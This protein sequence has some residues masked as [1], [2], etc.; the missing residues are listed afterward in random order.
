MEL[1]RIFDIPEYQKKKYPKS[2]ALNA[3][4][5]GQWRAYG[6]DECIDNINK[7]SLALLASGI[8]KD[9]KISIISNNRPEWNFVDFGIMQIGAVNVPVYPTSAEEDYVFIFNDAEVKMVFVSS[10]ELF[11]KIQNIKSRIPSL[12]EVFTFNQVKGASHFSEFMER[13]K[14]GSV[15]E[16]EK[17]KSGITSDDIST[18]IY[19][20]G[21]TGFPKGVM[22]SHWNVL[23]DVIAAKPLMPVGEKDKALS[24]LPLNHSFEKMISYLYLCY[25]I[26]IYY[27]ES[28]DTIGDN[29]REV[30]PQIMT[31]VP[32][33]LEKVYEKIL[34]KGQEQKGIKRALFFWALSLGER[35]DN[36]KSNG[37]FYPIQMAIANKLVFSKWRAALGGQ[38]KCVVTGAAPM[39]HKLLRI[40]TAAKITI[41]EGYGLTET[42]PAISVSRFN[43]DENVIGCVGPAIPGVEIKIAEDGEIL[44]R[45][46][47]VMKGYYKRPDLT[48]EVIDKDGWLHTGD[49]G[50]LVNGK[51]LKITDRKKELFKTSGGKYVAPQPIENKFKEELL[52]EQMIVVGASRKF[53]AALIVPSANNLK[54]WCTQHGINFTNTSEMIR[55]EAVKKKFEQLV[56][57]NNKLFGH[58][59]QIKK[60]TL[61]PNEWTIADGELTPTLKLKRKIIEKKFE[62]EIEAMYEEN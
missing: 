44:C 25:G 46:A 60:F 50:E 3:K 8:K 16:L 47:I 55:N 9:D 39:Q 26:S 15:T 18:I 61:V 27:A 32:R 14:N 5:N 4:E 29:L 30:K 56:A 35:W 48:A 17:I 6:I 10:E 53:P 43:L 40:F 41:M 11:L 37:I 19:T 12:K 21:T 62:K 7:V 36:Q 38:L 24:F 1:K 23:S 58:S 28:M 22:L 13:G 52:I 45:G 49:I 51:F 34:S 20:S 2:D 59:E 31:C 54:V 33:L 42:S 57:E